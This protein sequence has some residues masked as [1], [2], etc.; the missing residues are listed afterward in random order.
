[1]VFQFLGRRVVVIS[2][3]GRWSGSG[4]GFWAVEWLLSTVFGRCSAKVT[5]I[6]KGGSL[7]T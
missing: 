4:F 5:K 1:M 6:G 7:N 2:V 3:S